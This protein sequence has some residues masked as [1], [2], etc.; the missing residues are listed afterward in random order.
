[1]SI[2]VHMVTRS[3]SSSGSSLPQPRLVWFV[4]GRH[5]GN[6]ITGDYDDAETPT[7]INPNE[8]GMVSVLF[9]H[10]PPRVMVLFLGGYTKWR[11]YDLGSRGCTDNNTYSTSLFRTTR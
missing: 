11:E 2:M 6:S 1:M 8:C 3:A 10:L 9:H 7:P 5:D 4:V